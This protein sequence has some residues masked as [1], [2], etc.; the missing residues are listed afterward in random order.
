MKNL[1]TTLLVLAS[2]SLLATCSF[3]PA[4]LKSPPVRG[5]ALGLFS[6]EADFD[7]AREIREIKKLGV[8]SILLN[9]SWFQPHIQA[10]VIRPRPFNGQ[11]EFTLPDEVLVG[12][13]QEAHR[14]GMSV[15]I[16]P[17]LRFDRL[18]PNE[19]RGVLQPQN[20]A[21]WS[22]QYEAFILHY[23]ALAEANGVEMLSV[24]S[25]LGSLEE[26][27]EFW[28]PL[29]RKVR[30]NYRGK[31]LYSANWDHYRYPTFWGQ[32]DFIGLTSYFELS[33][34]LQPEYEELLKS[35]QRRKKEI[36]K[37][38]KEHPQKIIFT[39]VGYPSL[40]GSAKYPWNYYASAKPDPE[41]QALCYRAFIQAWSDTPE[42]AGVYW[43]IWFG[44]GRAYGLELYASGQARGEIGPTMVSRALGPRFF[45]PEIR[46]S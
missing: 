46:F 10:N 23:A 27:D 37:F 33:Q 42:L 5:M 24:G 31:L 8:N 22:N 1:R 2:L 6:K 21:E 25:E 18:M 40:D 16:F 32:L 4:R 35:W 34:S 38:Q 43:W 14:Q 19:W 28:M 29:I 3:E 36:L 12:V 9:V 20:F 41:E 30:Q 15:L 39:E 7:Y 11:D 17:Y 13:I 45:L 44:E 26:K